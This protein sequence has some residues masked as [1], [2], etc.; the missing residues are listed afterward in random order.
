MLIKTFDAFTKPTTLQINR[1]TEFFSKHLNGYYPSS[2]D[3]I[4]EA[5]LYAIKEKAGFGGYIFQLEE[6]E[7]LIGALVINKTGMDELQSDFILVYIAIRED[8]RRQGC[9]TRLLQY[10][11]GFC[12]G[13]ISVNLEPD[14]PVNRL[15]SSMGFRK[16][17]EEWKLNE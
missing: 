17:F 16:A 15:F 9:A 5:L 13:S 1:I 10:A 7:E 3:G 11:L 6:S 14:S 4:R 8:Y 2:E 12:K